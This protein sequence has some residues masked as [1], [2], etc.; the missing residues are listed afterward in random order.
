LSIV[1]QTVAWKEEEQTR[2][3]LE[4]GIDSKVCNCLLVLRELA[5]ENMLLRQ[6]V[7]DKK[8]AVTRLKKQCILQKAQ[9]R[10][11]DKKVLY[12]LVVAISACTIA[13][14]AMYARF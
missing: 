7:E 14:C 13:L 10:N 1:L 2:A 12:W 6:E 9:H 8:Q 5:A 4:R 11:M 3:K